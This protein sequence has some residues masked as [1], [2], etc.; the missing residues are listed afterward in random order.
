MERIRS[1]LRAYAL[2]VEVRQGVRIPLGTGGA[3]QTRALAIERAATPGLGFATRYVPAEERTSD[4][5]GGDLEKC[6]VVVAERSV[7]QAPHVKD[8]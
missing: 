4:S 7:A 3:T 1:A 6:D 8:A 5:I 2:E